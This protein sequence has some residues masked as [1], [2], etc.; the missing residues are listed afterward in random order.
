MLI[1]N[2]AAVALSFSRH[3]VFLVSAGRTARRF[4]M[5]TCCRSWRELRGRRNGQWQRPS[6][7]IRAVGG[8][9]V[10]V[11]GPLPSCRQ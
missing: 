11:C 9:A 2:A 3:P 8:N 5:R 10:M 6:A 1:G 7:A 4:S